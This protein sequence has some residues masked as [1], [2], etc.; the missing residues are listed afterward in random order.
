MV[1]GWVL[2]VVLTN[3]MSPSSTNVYYGYLT[4]A[5]C[6]QIAAQPVPVKNR[7]ICFKSR[8]IS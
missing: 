5:E 7:W 2:L 1:T 3:G 8:S 4:E 6:K